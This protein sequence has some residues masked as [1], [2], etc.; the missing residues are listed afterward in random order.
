MCAFNALQ[1]QAFNHNRAQLLQQ[2]FASHHGAT[3]CNQVVYQ[4]HALAREHRIGV[5]FDSGT[6][7]LQLVGLR[8]SG[9]WQL[10][11]FSNGHKTK[12]Q[13]IGQH[14]PHNEAARI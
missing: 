6:A 9:E 8:D 4:D 1:N 12:S 13:L 5:K 14:R 3:S 7:V 11:F 2:Q 10:A